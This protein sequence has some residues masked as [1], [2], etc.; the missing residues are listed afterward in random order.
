MPNAE[1][2]TIISTKGEIALP[3][4]VLKTLGW[5]SGVRLSVETI[6]DGVILKRVP[7]FTPTKP[8]DVAGSLKYDGPPVTIE[9]M[10]K[11]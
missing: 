11:G 10:D 3:V 7:L 5:D 2:K 1:L 4:D 8:E 9:E 6:S